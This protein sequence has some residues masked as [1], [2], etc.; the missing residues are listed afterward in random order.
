MLCVCVRKRSRC[1]TPVRLHRPRQPS[2][3]HSY[4]TSIS[5]RT[6]WG[7]WWYLIEEY[8]S[9]PG[10]SSLD[11]PGTDMVLGFA[12][13]LSHNLLSSI[14][15]QSQLVLPCSQILLRLCR[16]L[17]TAD[18]NVCLSEDAALTIALLFNNSTQSVHDFVLLW[19]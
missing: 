18:C 9:L 10:C 13:L 6:T 5:E 4:T 3:E 7:H 15:V 2:C 11:V 16:S 14:V 1:T 19:S 12:V 8:C 17:C